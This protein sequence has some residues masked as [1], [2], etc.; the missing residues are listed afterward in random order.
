ML[1]SSMSDKHMPVCGPSA[2][3]FKEDRMKLTKVVSVVLC[4]AMVAGIAGCGNKSK[5][6]SVI[7]DY[8]KALQTCDEDAVIALSDFNND[9]IKEYHV[10]LIS[11]EYHVEK[12]NDWFETISS[13]I[14]VTYDP[15]EIE[16]E[17]NRTTVKLTYELVDYQRVTAD[18]EY[19]NADE[20]IEQLK[21]CD[22]TIT[23]EGRITLK[24][25]DGEWMITK[26]TNLDQ[27]LFHWG[28]YPSVILDEA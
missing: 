13:T 26:I 24:K 16:I 22:R 7:K 28:M 4:L 15:K 17:D 21:A 18:E 3:S 12:L 27:V 1:R 25:I 23:F 8:E 5:I 20:L 10:N 9:E 14:K 2:G 19:N 6:E 11:N